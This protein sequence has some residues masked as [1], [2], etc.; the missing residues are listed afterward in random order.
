MS[1]KSIQSNH[2][3]SHQHPNNNTSPKQTISNRQSQHERRM[4]DRSLNHLL[5]FTLPPR[6]STLT[7]LPARR[8]VKRHASNHPSYDKDRF[9]HAQYRF[10]LKPT[11][12]YTAHFADPDI[13][14]HWPDILQVIVHA[15]RSDHST[16]EENEMG[17]LSKL[18]C[19]ICLSPAMAA[20]MT[21]CGHVFCYSCLL[22]YLELSEEKKGEGR[23][24]PVCTD[25]VMKKDLKSVK[26]LNFDSEQTHLRFRL[27]ERPT[28]STLA[29]PRSSTW[30]SSAIEPLQSPW[31]FTPDALTH[32][33]F[34]VAAPDYM[35]NELNTDLE[36]LQTELATL[37]TWSASDTQADLGIV[38]VRAAEAKVREQIVKVGL[39]KTTAVMTSRKKA[40]RQISAI[41]DQQGN[42][43]KERSSRAEDLINGFVSTTDEDEEGVVEHY[44]P[45]DPISNRPS[46]TLT[47]KNVNPP[48]AR[49]PPY[50]FYQAA[51]GQHVYLAPLDIR[52]LL[53]RFGSYDDFPNELELEVESSNEGRMTDSLRK[54][55]KYL[56][57]LPTGTS[58]RM[59]ETKI[60][61]YLKA[62]DT[63]LGAALRQ[64]RMRR[65]EQLR[66]E[67]RARL[68]SEV[69][70]RR[71]PQLEFDEANYSS[72]GE[73]EDLLSLDINAD[74]HG[75][76]P[77]NSTNRAGAEERQSRSEEEIPSGSRTVWG[78]RLVRRTETANEP[79]EGDDH[80][81]WDA[82][83]K[84]VKDDED[85]ED[86][87][88]SSNKKKKKKGR[89]VINISGGYGG[90]G[91]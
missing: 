37:V 66:K 78:T 56:S 11:G 64:R 70:Q 74:A 10:I 51:S 43:D 75:S 33:K 72:L 55:C 6:S 26:W 91:G 61:G 87:K 46:P 39:L 40:L 35:N 19:P 44:D 7:S 24:C 59:V 38:F 22:H 3:T 50:R 48:E 12:D 5:G 45:A 79:L 34:M 80:D 14:F 76:S 69:Q 73:L 60:D 17:G 9:V 83:I 4:T 53:A 77:E 86:Q 88:N 63:C 85:R 65:K 67:E 32:A 18:S 25:P 1:T 49:P 15:S 13:R 52:I 89:V 30:P 71:H 41:V 23:K 16:H 84:G 27:I 8:S 2:Q 28:F 36:E 29:L 62:D 58:V 90:R 20:R 82:V 68:K 42:T 81:V 31:H 21:K 47:R 57:H 54:R